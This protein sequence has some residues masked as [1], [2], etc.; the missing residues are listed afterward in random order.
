MSAVFY[1]NMLFSRGHSSVYEQAF[2]T[3]T[4]QWSASKANVSLELRQIVVF[5]AILCQELSQAPCL[6]FDLHE[7][8]AWQTLPMRNV[9]GIGKESDPG[10]DSE[11]KLSPR[12]HAEFLALIL[13]LK[14]RTSSTA[15]LSKISWI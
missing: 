2:S 12:V 8:S 10:Q 9:K 11:L 5:G 6:P 13:S 7:D 15:R 14:A 1:K 3:S 4:L